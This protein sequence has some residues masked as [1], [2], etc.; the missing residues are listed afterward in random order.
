MIVFAK[1]LQVP[2]SDSKDKKEEEHHESSLN[3]WQIAIVV[4]AAVCACPCMLWGP[5]HGWGLG[6]GV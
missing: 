1:T 6:V 3:W 4:T 2:G 5:A